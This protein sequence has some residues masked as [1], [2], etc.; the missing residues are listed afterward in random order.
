MT[1]D[2]SSVK[3]E[4][5][6]E[7]LRKE[8]KRKMDE[9]S[10]RTKKKQERIPKMIAIANGATPA[11]DYGQIIANDNIKVDLFKNLLEGFRTPT[12]TP[13]HHGK[14]EGPSLD[15]QLK[16]FIHVSQNGELHLV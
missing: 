6:K 7:A 2:L 16:G 1:A 12:S 5:E 14:P 13:G 9:D 8:Y 3:T 10:V 11:F 4:K 15:E